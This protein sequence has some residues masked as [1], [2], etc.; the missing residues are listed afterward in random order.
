MS[1]TDWASSIGRSK[2]QERLTYFLPELTFISNDLLYIYPT[3][4][5]I[6]DL[7][8]SSPLYALFAWI[9]PCFYRLLIPSVIVLSAVSSMKI[10]LDVVFFGPGLFLHLL[11]K[12]NSQAPFFNSLFSFSVPSLDLSAFKVSPRSCLC[13]PP[14]PSHAFL[15]LR[16]DSMVCIS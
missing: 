5:S 16:S 1:I 3:L 4:S 2:P 11:T 9:E 7:S 14:A 12:S 13:L 15:Y 8:Y 10:V 6:H